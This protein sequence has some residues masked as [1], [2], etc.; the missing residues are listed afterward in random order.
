MDI[1]Q[2]CAPH[3]RNKWIKKALDDKHD[4]GWI[5]KISGFF[6]KFMERVV[7]QSLDPV[8]GT[9]KKSHKSGG[10]ASSFHSVNSAQ[11]SPKSATNGN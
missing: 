8:C 11:A 10:K 5:S 3:I 1:V 9:Q 2:R 6:F 4:K 7:K